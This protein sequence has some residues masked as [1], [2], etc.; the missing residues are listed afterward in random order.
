MALGEGLYS[1]PLRL[2]IAFAKFSLISLWR[3]YS[4]SVFAIRVYVVSTSV[5]FELPAIPFEHFIRSFR[6]TS[7]P[8][9]SH[10]THSMRIH[11]AFFSNFLKKF[12]NR[13]FYRPFSGGFF[14]FLGW[15]H[16]GCKTVHL[17]KIFRSTKTKWHFVGEKIP[18]FWPVFWPVFVLHGE[19][20]QKR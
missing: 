17:K 19:E 18:L 11:Q 4:F 10:Y 15:V 12:F 2:M 9:Q 7:S 3:G 14:A 16:T 1:S 13:R 20:N 8:L 5:P 6:F